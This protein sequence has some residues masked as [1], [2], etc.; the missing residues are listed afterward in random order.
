MSNR[1]TS[2]VLKNNQLGNK[3]KAT[4]KEEREI[5]VEGKRIPC[6]IFTVS[7]ALHP[8]FEIIVPNL[9]NSL[10]FEGRKEVEL[11]EVTL[12]P[13]AKR[14]NIGT[15]SRSLELQIFAKQLLTL[16]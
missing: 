3:I 2:I 12:V 8:D 14:N 11:R 10:R 6:R 15:V 16:N 7:S 9:R 1:V 13:S 5:Y 4:V